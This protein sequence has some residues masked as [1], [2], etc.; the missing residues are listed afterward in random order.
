MNFF[1]FDILNVKFNNSTELTEPFSLIKCVLFVVYF[2]H[3]WWENDVK[4]LA[5]K[6]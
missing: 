6:N 2:C 5:S 3:F 1:H 4:K